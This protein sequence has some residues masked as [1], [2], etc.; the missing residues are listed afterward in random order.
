MCDMPLDR[1][2]ER[3]EKNK[4]CTESQEDNV[5]RG[6]SLPWRRGPDGFEYI[7]RPNLQSMD[8]AGW[9]KGRYETVKRLA[10]NA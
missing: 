7:I 5:P 2:V 9:N 3:K 10:N 1:F 6:L 8:S 4:G